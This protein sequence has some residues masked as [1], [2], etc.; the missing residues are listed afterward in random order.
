MKKEVVN[1]TSKKRTLV[2]AAAVL[3]LSGFAVLYVKNS[4]HAK[5]VALA[6]KQTQEAA[7]YAKYLALDALKNLMGNGITTYKMAD[8]FNLETL[9]KIMNEECH[10][11][12]QDNYTSHFKAQCETSINALIQH[13]KA[14]PAVVEYYQANAELMNV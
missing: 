6:E 4:N 14:N 11:D 13:L 10:N 9:E 7:G 12:N 3:V 1:H 8:M 5:Q 2:L